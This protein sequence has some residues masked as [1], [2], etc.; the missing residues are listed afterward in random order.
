MCS[1]TPIEKKV[2]HRV[3]H[4]KLSRE[5]HLM[6]PRTQFRSQ[7][8]GPAKNTPL[9]VGTGGPKISYG[10]AQKNAYNYAKSTS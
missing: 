4:E 7:G 5:R 2:A 6:V 1:A 9:A 10:R 8:S 3:L